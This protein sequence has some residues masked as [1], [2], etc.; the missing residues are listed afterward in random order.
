M[1]SDVVN[2]AMLIKS[3]QPLPE[4]AAWS[5]LDGMLSMQLK[6]FDELECCKL[7]MA[8]VKANIGK[9]M[10]K[11]RRCARIFFEFSLIRTNVIRYLLYA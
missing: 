6:I 8:A 11:P 3:L 5:N 7:D 4:E 10:K 2:I 1:S 9:L